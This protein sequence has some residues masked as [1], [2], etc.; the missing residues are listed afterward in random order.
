MIP[1]PK[2]LG[3][4]YAAQFKDRSVVQAY[5]LRPPYPAE[6]FEILASLI[7][8]EP[9][10]VL[11]VG[12]GT[13][14]VARRLLDIVERVDAVDFSYEMIER[15]KRLPG[16]DCPNLNWIY[17]PVEEVPLSPPY[18]LIT[19]GS[20]LH[21]MEWDVVFPRFREVL[22]P[23]GFVAILS[24]GAGA[25]T[26]WSGELGKIIRRYST[27]Q[28]FPQSGFSIFSLVEELEVRRLFRKVGEK[29]T[30]PVTFAQAVDDFVESFHSMNGFSRERMS[31]EMASAFDAEVK[32]LISKF[33]REGKVEQQVVGEIIWGVSREV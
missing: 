2:H 22:T 32:N 4:E 3:P 10:T 16:G 13:G 31:R 26:P 33:S 11:D 29:R 8:D 27:N 17:G 14:E 15:G 21:W 25:P 30:A 24:T 12:C 18:A 20:S 6:T 28:G 23:R 9:R 1:K 19:A 5:H 7:T